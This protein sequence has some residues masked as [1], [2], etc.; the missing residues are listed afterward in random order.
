MLIVLVDKNPQQLGR[1]LP[2]LNS[3][4][5]K[6]SNPEVSFLLAVNA[7]R[8]PILTYRGVTAALWFA[9]SRLRSAADRQRR[10]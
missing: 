7:K 10:S 5:T 2:D 4:T 8:Q 1:R 9:V 6:K 3:S